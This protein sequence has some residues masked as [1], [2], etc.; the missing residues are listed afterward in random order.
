[1]L[2][3]ISSFCS[4]LDIETDKKEEIGQEL[5]EAIMPI[6]YKV[7]EITAEAN[8]IDHPIIRNITTQENEKITEIKP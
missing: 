7:I 5:L 8:F 4:N 2:K 6:V 3:D 1:M